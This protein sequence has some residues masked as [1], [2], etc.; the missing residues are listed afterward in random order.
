LHASDVTAPTVEAVAAT[1]WGKEQ[2][3]HDHCLQHGLLQLLLLL[4]G[5]AA[6]LF[7]SSLHP[8][9]VPCTPLLACRAFPVLY[10]R[11]MV[12][13]S[14]HIPHTEL[15]PSPVECTLVVKL[16]RRQEVTK[17]RDG[18]VL[19]AAEGVAVRLAC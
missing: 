19:L 7:T 2:P 12:S 4:L 17:Q 6:P 15:L 18:S 13:P 5:A 16:S 14:C 8:F 9:P 1:S 3:Q 10:E 11:K